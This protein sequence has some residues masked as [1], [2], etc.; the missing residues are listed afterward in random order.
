MKLR[1]WR[2]IFGGRSTLYARLA[3][4]VAGLTYLACAARDAVPG[5]SAR[6]IADHSGISPFPALSYGLWGLAG[7]VFELL[8]FGSLSFR[9]NLLS[10]V[11]G[12]ICSGLVCS[13][14]PRLIGND[15]DRDLTAQDKI[16]LANLAGI[17]ASLLLVFS[18]PF[19]LAST[20][21]HPGTF[22]L[23]LLLTVV[24]LVMRYAET[25]RQGYILWSA[26]LFGVTVT[27]Y[28]TA[29]ALMPLYTFAAVYIMWSSGFLMDG[30]AVRVKP[31]VQ[32]LGF[33]AIGL[34]PYF[35]EAAWFM[36]QPAYTWSGMRGIG[37]VLENIWREQ[38]TLIRYGL[39][40]VGW[41][42]VLLFSATPFVM[43]VLFRKTMKFSTHV[44]LAVS[45]VIGMLLFFNIRFAPWPM[46]GVRPLLLMPYVIGSVCCGCVAS[47]S[48]ASLLGTW[49][50]RSRR[51]RTPW[52]EAAIRAVYLVAV[53]A[54]IIAAAVLNF[55]N[56]GVKSAAAITRFADEAARQ[57]RENQWLLIDDQLEP[58]IRIKAAEIGKHVL[59]LTTARFN[60]PPQQESL[61]AEIGDARLCN[62]IY[63]GIVPFI[64]EALHPSRTNA[65]AISVIGENNALR[66]AAGSLLPEGLFYTAGVA[67]PTDMDA[68]AGSQKQIWR[69]IGNDL[70]NTEDEESPFHDTHRRLL[71]AISKTAND[72]GVWLEDHGRNDLAIEAY[73][74]AARLS[75]INLSARLNLQKLIDT[76]SEEAVSLTG[77]IESLSSDIRGKTDIN[78][79][80]DAYG[81]IKH[82]DSLMSDAAR[83]L[84]AGAIDVAIETL[85]KALAIRDN[86]EAFKLI[87][88]S[89][90]AQQ[91]DSD[92]SRQLLSDVAKVDAENLPALLGIVHLSAAQGRYEIADKFLE[93]LREKGAAPEKISIEAANIDMMRGDQD[94]AYAKLMQLEKD[95]VKDPRIWA[96]LALI[97]AETRPLDA[98]RYIDQLESFPNLVPAFYLPLAR[99]C[100]ARGRIDHAVTH[101]ENLLKIQPLNREALRL[102]LRL[103]LQ[104]GKLDISKPVYSKL[105]MADPRD[106]L[107]NY[108][109]GSMLYR[110]GKLDDAQTAWEVSLSSEPLPETQNDYA[111]L[112]HEKGDDLKALVMVD[113]SLKTR[114]SATAWHTKSVVLMSL[115]RVEEAKEAVAQ[116]LAL[117]PDNRE[118]LSR[119]DE[120]GM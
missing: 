32:L 74:E 115:G 77:Q 10:V 60:Y 106:S 66:F 46:L 105:L 52:L 53:F 113:A 64:K 36:N 13:I 21:A 24:W 54:L 4:A 19:R 71:L 97:T 104:A 26:A 108:A 28:A 92:R 49:F 73:R 41:T 40:G 27:Q 76:N 111:Q 48:L 25:K 114:A 87:L 88:A 67:A 42:V 63:A 55:R 23:M 6:Y 9:W 2:T 112:L 101:L 12:A 86:D 29:V 16:P 81:I 78:T 83:W 107:A 119:R 82:P 69:G 116:G 93:I 39:P 102:L 47:Y 89:L 91:G 79:I 94:S 75:P 37:A 45:A 20:M 100:V 17:T 95:G 15:L 62:M 1:I 59:Y 44:M 120:L 34:L 96:M 80:M 5:D 57:L 90:S 61:R 43:V 18:A 11:C 72:T 30:P 38:Y 50:V 31:L 8:P 22:N 118:L 109:L 84:N 58:L 7:R 70:A 99:I 85:E 3:T 103:Q 110:H 98:D 65:P 68:Y 33:F 51:S 117:Q 56:A 14:T 35:I